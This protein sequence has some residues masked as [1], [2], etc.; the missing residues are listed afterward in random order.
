MYMSIPT[1]ISDMCTYMSIPTA[2]SDMCMCPFR[3]AFLTCM[4]PFRRAFLICTW[5]LVHFWPWVPHPTQA[6]SHWRDRNTTVRE[7]ERMEDGTPPRCLHRPPRNR[8]RTAHG[9]RRG[10]TAAAFGHRRRRRRRRRYLHHCCYHHRHCCV[11]TVT[12]SG[13]CWSVDD[14]ILKTDG[15]IILTSSMRLLNHSKET[16]QTRTSTKI[17]RNRRLERLVPAK[18]DT[19]GF[20]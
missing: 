20:S 12:G 7:R 5:L 10:V 14:T 15:I 3:R 4:C 1:V 11:A 13:L 2:V 18:K 8:P 19:V 16:P 17:L 9:L 6:Y